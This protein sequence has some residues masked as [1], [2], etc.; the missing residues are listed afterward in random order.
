VDCID[1]TPHYLLLYH[2]NMTEGEPRNIIENWEKPLAGRNV[3]I[4]GGTSGTGLETA[5]ELHKLGAQIII[6]T[7]NEDNFNKSATILGNEKVQ[8]FIADLSDEAQIKNAIA[9]LKSQNLRPTDIVHSAAGGMESFLQKSGFKLRRL[10]RITDES[11]KQEKISELRTELI[12]K[13][14]LSLPEAKRINYEGP[15]IFFEQMADILAPN[16]KIIYYSSLWSSVFGQKEADIPEFYKGIAS[17]KNLF[18]RWMDENADK[19]VKRG[20]YP[21]II[22]GHLIADSKA[23]KAVSHFILPLASPQSKELMEKSFI[24]KTDMVKA[25][26]DALQSDPKKWDEVP[27]RLF[28]T[29]EGIS[30]KLSPGNSVFRIHLPI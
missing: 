20:I 1:F 22:S 27:L 9:K 2:L 6:G 29:R 15:K 25:T 23:G 8:P 13:V 5:I 21:A 10:Q 24:A 7:R 4:T 19:L 11:E 16:S 12:E 18:E 3:L 14:K 30:R 26:L 28:V 17:T